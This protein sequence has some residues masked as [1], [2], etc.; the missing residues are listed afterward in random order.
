MA[1]SSPSATPIDDR[2]NKID[3]HGREPDLQRKYP[4][5]RHIHDGH[6]VEDRRER[7]KCNGAKARE[8]Q[9]QARP[10][11]R[12]LAEMCIRDRQR[13]G[14]GMVGQALS[15]AKAHLLPLFT[16]IRPY[17]TTKIPALP[18]QKAG[19]IAAVTRHNILEFRGHANL[20]VY[21]RQLGIGRRCV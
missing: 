11:I 20:A 21:F 17:P 18:R 13:S 6:E 5:L 8:S 14:A 10:Q 19:I 4:G 15:P 1:D 3:G 16:H 12:P 2:A 7:S 9:S